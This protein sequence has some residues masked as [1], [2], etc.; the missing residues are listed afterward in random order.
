MN[1]I[2]LG[3]V[4]H[5]KNPK[6]ARIVPRFVVR[7]FEA[8]VCQKKLNDILDVYGDCDPIEFIGGALDYIGVKYRLHGVENIPLNGKIL[9][10]ANHPLGGIDGMILAH[11]IEG[12]RPGVK[13]IVN[14]ILLNIEPLE[15]IFV[16]VNKHGAQRCSFAK[17]MDELY[18]SDAPIINFPSGMCS[19]LV[20]G[21]IT[22]LPWRKSFV[23]R[24]IDTQRVVVPT[25]VKARNSMF[26]YRFARLRTALGI[27]VNLD[28]VLLPRQIFF[29]K[30][31]TVEIFFGEPITM[32][33]RLSGEEWCD[34]IREK[35]YSLWKQ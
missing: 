12:V 6:L 24:A 8:L 4:L 23:R 32:D 28:M 2:D 22:D 15:P 29:Q 10:A 31:K 16:G 21:E 35:T 33:D 7:W 20:H 1:R 34:L 13:L 9:F 26:F 19:R 25:Y 3:K 5:D 27:K 18:R 30:G 17:I 14:D 11:A